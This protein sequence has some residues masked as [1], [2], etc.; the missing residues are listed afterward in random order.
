MPAGGPAALARQ[1]RRAAAA[2][3]RIRAGGEP[4][5]HLPDETVV[6]QRAGAADPVQGFVHPPRVCQHSRMVETAAEIAPRR[7]ARVASRRLRHVAWEDPAVLGEAADEIDRLGVA[8]PCGALQPV[9][10]RRFVLRHALAK[11]EQRRVIVHRPIEPA[12]GG[13]AIAFRR[14]RLV[15]PRAPAE[16]VAAP[17]HVERHQMLLRRRLGEPAER[18]D[19]VRGDAVAVEQHLPEHRLCLWQPRLRRAPDERSVVIGKRSR[20]RQKRTPSVPNTVRP[21]ATCAKCVV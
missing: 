3:G 21:V 18:R 11:R 8:E 19:R 9:E 16:V 10:R 13:D 17:D 20:G 1:R 14:A 6:A 7:G 5:A 12:L 2:Q 4:V 15:D